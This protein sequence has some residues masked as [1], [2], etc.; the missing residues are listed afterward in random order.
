MKVRH[1]KK[2]DGKGVIISKLSNMGT[3]FKCQD[4][5]GTGHIVTEE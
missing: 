1:C 5:D 3:I 4:C 2:C